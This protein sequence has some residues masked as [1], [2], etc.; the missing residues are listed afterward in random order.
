[1]DDDSIKAAIVSRQQAIDAKM[2][3]LARYSVRIAIEE[4]QHFLEQIVDEVGEHLH[5][6]D[7]MALQDH[8]AAMQ[9]LVKTLGAEN[10]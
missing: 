1:M 7:L 8:L 9:R 2:N 5:A 6:P 10:L 4:H 3:Q